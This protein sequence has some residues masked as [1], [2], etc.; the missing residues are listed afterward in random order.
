METSSYLVN[1]FSANSSTH[2]AH[3]SSCIGAHQRISNTADH[4]GEPDQCLR[5]LLVGE[6]TIAAEDG[7]LHIAGSYRV[8]EVGLDG[9]MVSYLA[10]NQQRN[11]KA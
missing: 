6:K 7:G 10:E 2:P 9:L 8:K 4:L 1:T 5:E 11:A 3:V